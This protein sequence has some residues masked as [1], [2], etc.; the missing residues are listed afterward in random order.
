MPETTNI[1]IWILLWAFA[2]GGGWLKA[3]MS[4][5]LKTDQGRAHNQTMHFWE[6][7]RSTSRWILF[8]VVA[9]GILLELNIDPIFY[10]LPWPYMPWMIL[11]FL[12]GA[13][14]TAVY[15]R[16]LPQTLR[17]LPGMLGAYALY[18]VST[19]LDRTFPVLYEIVYDGMESVS[20]HEL[21]D[22]FKHD[23]LKLTNL[24]MH[25]SLS[26]WAALVTVSASLSAALIREEVVDWF[27]ALKSF[28]RQNKQRGGEVGRQWGFIRGR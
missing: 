5:G 20:R 21:S 18:V 15:E 13:G 12:Y 6:T 1:W 4:E 19:L 10:F 22:H 7:S 9:L 28:Y 17:F 8:T 23:L 24:T 25:T 27:E 16:G 3:P 2:Y 14:L 26:P 11:G